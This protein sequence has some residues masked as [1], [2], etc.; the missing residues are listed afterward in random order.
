MDTNRPTNGRDTGQPRFIPASRYVTR[1]R[2][3]Q[4]AL[5]RLVAW[6]STGDWRLLALGLVC[7]IVAA[8]LAV[9]A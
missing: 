2:A 1:H 4:R 8:I 6:L 5:V 9:M 7:L 3:R